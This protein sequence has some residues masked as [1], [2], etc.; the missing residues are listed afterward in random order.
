MM[1]RLFFHVFVL[2]LILS[3]TTSDAVEAAQHRIRTGV[4]AETLA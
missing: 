3:T 2:T 4:A 1:Q